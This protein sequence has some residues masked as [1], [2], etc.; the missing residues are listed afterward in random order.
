LIRDT[1]KNIL[2]KFPDKEVLEL[3][4]FIIDSAPEDKGIPIGNQ[5][6]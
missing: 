2:S 4:Y 6:S 5:T 1:L 3:L